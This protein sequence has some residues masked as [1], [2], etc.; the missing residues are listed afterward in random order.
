MELLLTCCASAE[1]E[2]QRSYRI[3]K[4]L[5][6]DP[7]WQALLPPAERHGLVQQLYNCLSQYSSEIP[8]HCLAELRMRF[9]SN[10]RQSLFLTQ[11]LGRVL[12][13]FERRRIEVLV[14]KGPV[15]AQML[16]GDVALR[17]F[18]DLDLLVRPADVQRCKLAL[19]EIGYEVNVVLNARE[20][21]AHFASGYEYVFDSAQHKSLIEVQWRILPRFYAVDFDTERL[22]DRAETISVCGRPVKT[23][24]GEDLLLVLCAHA[25]KH[26]WQKI[27]WI[28]D[29]AELARLR[30]INWHDVMAEAERLGILR[31][32]AV[33]FF[34]AQEMLDFEIPPEVQHFWQS[35]SGSQ[36]IGKEILGRIYEAGDIDTDSPP[37]FRL[38]LHLRERRIDRIRFLSRLAL[39]PTI[40]EWRAVKLPTALFPAYRA[41]RVGR[42]LGRAFRMG[43]HFNSSRTE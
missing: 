39:T 28:R 7:P 3:K 24:D 20:E 42:L 10:V 34:L 9:Q 2:E 37:Y 29:V 14:L 18:S 17:Q 30:Q 38:M 32:V 25:A 36:R 12:D 21:K 41:V 27:V 19:T 22:F 5:A 13:S 15:L 23:I 35:D 6:A 43:W 8:S 26:L 31:I 16:Y 1:S 11:L 33:T 4:L 40:S